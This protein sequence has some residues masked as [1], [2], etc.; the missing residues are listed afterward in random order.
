MRRQRL[1][2]GADLVGDVAASGGAVGAGDAEIDLAVAHQMPAGI[3]GDHGV[4]HAVLEQLPGGE[5]GALVA[6][7]RLVDP[8]ME[9][10]ALVTRAVDR[11]QRG[12]PIDRRQP[13]GV[14]MRQNLDR[15]AAFAALRRGDQ[16]D[17]VVADRAVDRD[18]LLGNLGGA[19]ERG[20]MP[21]ARR[22]REE[23]TAHRFKRPTQVD[24]CRPGRGEH[25]DRARQRRIRRVGGGGEGNAVGRRRADQRRAAHRHVADRPRR[26]VQRR[27]PGN[28]QFVRQKPLVDDLD[29][30]PIRAEPDRAHR[31]A[32]NVH[33][34]SL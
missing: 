21:A 8:D 15:A 14:A 27:Q 5:A 4:R 22:Q 34:L 13:A 28:D 31:P 12:A 30:A 29:R 6:R 11:R 23:R 7:A 10:N 19:G 3:V 2:V 32:A 9:G 17:T 1:Q 24:R 16:I 33:R 26:I 25:V 18:I 20:V